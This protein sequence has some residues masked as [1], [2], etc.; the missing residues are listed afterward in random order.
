MKVQLTPSLVLTNNRPESRY[1]IPVLVNRSDE[2]RAYGPSDIISV[3]GQFEPAAHV[4]VRFAKANR[5][6]GRE[7]E[8]ARLFCS[9]WP[10]GP[11]IGK[12]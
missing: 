7:L 11:Q 8:A 9:Q 6:A 1:R 4:V 5:L 10:E 2:T 3:Y 12:E